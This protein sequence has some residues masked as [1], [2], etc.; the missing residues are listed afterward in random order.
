MPVGQWACRRGQVTAGQTA[1]ITGAGP[2]GL[3]AVQAAVS[4]GAGEVVVADLSPYRLDVAR[5]LGATAVIDISNTPLRDSEAMADVLLECSG[6]QAAVQDGI[7]LLRPTG[8]A[9]LVGMGSDEVSLPTTALQDRE[10]EVTGTFRYAN[11]Y[12]AAI[13]LVAADRIDLD[14]LVTGHFPLEQAEAALLAGRTDATAINSIV[15][16]A[17]AEPSCSS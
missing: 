14:A 4:V 9:V 5:G 16:P 8:R 1:L 3:C 12:P 7:D 13:A 11:T 10:I 15:T 17:R 6:A 2:V